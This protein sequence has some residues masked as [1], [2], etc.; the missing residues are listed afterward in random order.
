M[1]SQVLPFPAG[2]TVYVQAYANAAYTQQ[3]TIQ[4]P[5]G[6]KPNSNAAVFSGNGE[7]NALQKLTTQGFLTPNSG[8][9]PSFVV[10]SGSSTQ[11]YT[12]SITASGSSSPVLGNVNTIVTPAGGQILVGVVSS[13]DSNDQDWN[14][15]VVLFTS[16]LPP[17]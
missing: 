16:Y 17:T 7:N 2:A 1:S 4:P 12:V 15:S 13:E 8:G 14:D 10:P 3:V 9:W 11:K 6:Q 5:S